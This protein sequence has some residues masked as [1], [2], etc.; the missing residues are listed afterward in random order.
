MFALVIVLVFAYFFTTR[1]KHVLNP[2]LVMHGWR[3]QIEN[4][5]SMARV[6]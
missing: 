5:G 3:N 6:S 1:K 2:V 4:L